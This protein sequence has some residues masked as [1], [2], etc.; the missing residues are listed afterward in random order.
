MEANSQRIL[1]H[2]VILSC[3]PQIHRAPP[4]LTGLSQTSENL[5]DLH[6]YSPLGE[7]LS[8]Q[9]STG[10]PRT[11]RRLSNRFFTHKHFKLLEVF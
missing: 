11:T 4:P 9:A 2:G 7:P 5:S 10:P 3:L 6:V 8:N 1:L